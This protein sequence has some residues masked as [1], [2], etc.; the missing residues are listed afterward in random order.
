MANMVR[1]NTLNQQYFIKQQD[2]AF[3]VLP[4]WESIIISL[5]ES[6]LKYDDNAAK[7]LFLPGIRQTIDIM[8]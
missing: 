8:K 4:D 5:Q 7:E 6:K 2:G 3:H 1:L